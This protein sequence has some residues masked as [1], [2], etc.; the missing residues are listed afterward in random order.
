MLTETNDFIQ[1][2]IQDVRELNEVEYWQFHNACMQ[3]CFAF[4]VVYLFRQNET[5]DDEYFEARMRLFKNGVLT[6]PGYCRWWDTW[7]E[8][9]L[10][11]RFVGYVERNLKGQATQILPTARG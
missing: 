1:D 6:R 8:E 11:E 10:D 7:A 2:D 9:V 5:V 4:E 3:M